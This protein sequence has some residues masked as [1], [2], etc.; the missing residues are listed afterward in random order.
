MLKSYLNERQFE[1]KI[2]GELSSRFHIHSG[3]SQG[4]ILG[5]LLYELY[6]SDLP[7]SKETTLSI[8]ADDNA[9]FATHEDPTIASLY[10]QEH[11]HIVEKWLKKWKTKVKESKLSY[12][13]FTLRK[14]H[15]PV[16]NINQITI[17]Q[18]E[19]VKYLGLHYDCMLNW[20]ENIAKKRKQTDLKT[21]EINSLIGKKNPIYLQK[22]RYSSTKRL[23]LSGAT[24]LNCGLAPASPT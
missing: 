20:K 15:C 3:V 23:D 12:I 21:K 7:T 8:F 10:L 6:T 16:F 9:I 24:E 14:G 1:T 19:V 13:T 18:T 11:L 2:N 4:R 22:I 5:P 17:P